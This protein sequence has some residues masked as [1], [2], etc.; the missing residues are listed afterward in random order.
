MYVL[1]NTI[2]SVCVFLYRMHGQY[3]RRRHYRML[4]QSSR[5]Q[6]DHQTSASI[7]LLQPQHKTHQLH[8]LHAHS[9]FRPN[10]QSPTRLESHSGELVGGSDNLFA[11]TD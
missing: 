8:I 11:V 2:Y 1:S 6:L 3:N 7:H 4:L 10:T 9:L 5:S